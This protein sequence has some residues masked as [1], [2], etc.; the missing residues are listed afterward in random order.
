MDIKLIPLIS[1]L[2]LLVIYSTHAV[3]PL[4][5]IPLSSPRRET[6]TPDDIEKHIQTT[7]DEI[8]LQ[9]NQ[10]N[11]PENPN[12]QKTAS[13]LFDCLRAASYMHELKRQQSP[14]LP[15]NSLTALPNNF[16]N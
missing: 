2:T 15:Y 10:L 1:I 8:V 16:S 5:P 6:L 3:K 9:Y 11:S 4:T 14:C 12:P 13:Q 7:E